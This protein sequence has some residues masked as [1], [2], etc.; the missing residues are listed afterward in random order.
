MRSVFTLC[1]VAHKARS[2]STRTNKQKTNTKKT[3]TKNN[4]QQA[5]ADTAKVGVGVT[6]EAQ[7]LFDALGKTMPVAWRGKA[8]VVMDAVS[9]ELG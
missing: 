9:S 6:V 4:S 5:E 1:K 7:A 2:L 8:V 3:T